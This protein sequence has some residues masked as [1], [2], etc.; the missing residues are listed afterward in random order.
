M[1]TKHKTSVLLLNLG[2]PDEPTAAAIRRYLREFLSDPRVLD[3]PRFFFF[4]LL[5]GVILPFRPQKVRAGY[6]AI[7]Q[8]LGSPLL[9]Y[10]Q[11]LKNKVAKNL[12]EDFDVRLAMRYGNPSIA[13]TLSNL[14]FTKRLVVIPLYPHYAASSTATA[15]AK[16]YE[17]LAKR[18]DVIPVSVHGDFFD[19]PQFI[20]L[21]VEMIRA[22]LAQAPDWDHLLFSYHGLPAR[23]LSRSGCDHAAEHCLKEICPNREEN[24]VHRCYRQQCYAGT[25][26]IVKSLGLEAGRYTVS[27]QSRLGRTPW[28]QP[29]TDLILPD[30]I[31]R[32]YRRL[33]VCSP[34]FVADCLETSDELDIRLRQQWQDLG[35]ESLHVV[36]SLNDSDAWGELIAAWCKDHVASIK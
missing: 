23:H 25:H 6:Q 28:I 30:L 10:S 11:S 2:T 29:Y 33:V 27:F 32:G 5:Y 12:G 21:Q 15:L 36:P 9:F 13:D 16:V 19:D 14:S 3:I 18:W 34:S 4:L 22:S 24:S 17:E 31:K 1:A 20:K 8:K 26:E 35:G 7:W